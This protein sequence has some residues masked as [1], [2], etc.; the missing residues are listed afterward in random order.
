MKKN[1]NYTTPMGWA[2]IQMVA[3]DHTN[4]LSLVDKYKIRGYFIS[5]ECNVNNILLT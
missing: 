3:Y 2:I 4:S 5:V 1:I